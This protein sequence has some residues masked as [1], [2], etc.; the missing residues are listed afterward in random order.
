MG[1]TNLSKEIIDSSIGASFIFQLLVKVF[2]FV[3]YSTQ[4]T[5]VFF[6]QQV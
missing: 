6:W 2:M 5:G 4:S 1:K 3:S